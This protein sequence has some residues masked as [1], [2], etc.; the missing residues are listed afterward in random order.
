MW[1]LDKAIVMQKH[2]FNVEIA[3]KDVRPET[4]RAGDLADFVAAMCQ[5]NGWKDEHREYARIY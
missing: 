2:T 1:M 4:T 3:G 5:K